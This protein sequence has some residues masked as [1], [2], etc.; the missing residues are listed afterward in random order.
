MPN[1]PPPPALIPLSKYAAPSK[2]AEDVARGLWQKAKVLFG[3]EEPTPPPAVEDS[4]LRRSTRGLLDDIV[5]PPACGP[6]IEEVAGSLDPWLTDADRNNRIRVVVR[7]PAGD[8]DSVSRWAESAGLAI[9]RPPARDRLLSHEAPAPEA[10]EAGPEAA[11]LVVPHL[12]RW[13]LRHRCGLDA[14]RHLLDRLERTR[15]PAVVACN[16]FAWAF[17]SASLGIDRRLPEPETVRAFDAARLQAWFTRL[18]DEG[19]HDDI[20]FRLSTTGAAVASTSDEPESR[21]FFDQLAARSRGVPAIAWH[22]WRR[23]LRSSED[24]EDTSEP[25]VAAAMSRRLWLAPL[26]SFAVPERAGRTGRLIL[27][28]LL[29]HGRLTVDE[30]AGVLPEGA[31][32]ASMAGLRHA[33]LIEDGRGGLRVRAAAYP[34]VY[35]ALSDA[36]FPVGAV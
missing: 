31:D 15:R 16:S 7:P 23:C 11:P 10:D 26:E 33:G 6:A 30:L 14:V 5:S 36:G 28:A 12:D 9:A 29:V 1:D 18:A 24:P 13:F 2:P 21:A 22:L 32:A 35:D 19:H 25:D 8:C 20:T 34:A 17:L 3:R 27:H 4:Q